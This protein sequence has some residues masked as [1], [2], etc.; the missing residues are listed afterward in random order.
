MVKPIKSYADLLKEPVD[1]WAVGPGLGKSRK[2]EI[3]QLIR[4]ATAPMVVDADGL[5]ILADDMETLK[6]AQG[7]RLLTPHPGEMQRI[8]PHE[9]M[10]RARI[11]NEFCA[12]YTVT[13]LLKGSRTIV[14]ESGH[15]LGYNTT[16]NP[17]MATGGMGDVLTG[18]CAALLGAKHSPNDS[19]RLGAWLCGRAAELALS[20]GDASEESLLP[21]D[22]LDHLGA[23]FNDLRESR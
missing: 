3:L 23:A 1:V 18:V 9:K 17:G 12:K 7:P 14:A 11:A 22:V 4:D 15:P 20:E 2:K 8:F 19:A 13:L 21:T 16:G 10:P 5:N 6:Q